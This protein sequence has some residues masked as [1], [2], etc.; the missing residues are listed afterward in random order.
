M[1]ISEGKIMDIIKSIIESP[2]HEKGSPDNYESRGSMWAAGILFN[3]L[4]SLLHHT[5]GI[6]YLFYFSHFSS[7]SLFNN[8][9][10]L[11]GLN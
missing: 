11:Q 8:H 6:F 2:E 9:F 1:A 4:P 5:A 3:L 7:F 10:V